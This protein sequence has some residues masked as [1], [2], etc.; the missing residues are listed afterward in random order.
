M[1]TVD[2]EGMRRFLALTATIFLALAAAGTFPVPA[3]GVVQAV[4]APR[5]SAP[6]ARSW[7]VAEIEIV[8]AA[9]IFGNEPE[10]FRATDPLTRGEL[11]AALV[12]WGK[13]ATVATDPG[14]LVTMR[15]L[16]AQLV[17]AL[18]LRDAARRIRASAQAAGMAPTSM[19]GTETVARLL[20]L[21][22]NHPQDQDEL[23]LLPNQPATRAEAAYSF[24]RALALSPGQISW[25]DQLSQTF[26]IPALGE[27]QSAVVTRA[28]RF[29]GYPYVWAGTSE[30]TQT[31]MECHSPGRDGHRSGRFRLLRLR[32][33]GVQDQA[34]PGRTAAGRHAEGEDD[35]CHE[36]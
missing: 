18:G 26:D 32:M 13:R 33:A 16:D 8:T 7:A 21:R 12:A 24:A 1:E 14:R 20:G 15:E 5:S 10:T 23:E 31:R 35:V 3:P 11:A 27:W 17:G 4:A 34:V 19:L 36:R 29:V 2:E 30:T 25:L 28:L 6:V 22:L 9:G